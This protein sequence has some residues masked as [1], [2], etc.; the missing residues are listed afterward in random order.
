[1]KIVV[2]GA[3]GFVG[4]AYFQ[5]F[6][7]ADGLTLHGV[8]R[9]RLPLDASDYTAIDLSQPFDLPF[10]PDVVLHAAARV[11]PW[12]TR[13]EYQRQN[14]DA[15]RHVIDFCHR[16]GLPR[17]VYV[18]SSSVFYRDGHQL[19]LTEESPIGPDFVNDYAATKYEGE[20]LV[21]AY[22][23]EWTIV[24][25]RA[26][27][28]PGDTVL[29]PRIVAAARR[30]RF[31]LID[32]G[33][34]PAVGDLIY[35]DT[36]T[37]YLHAAVAS[38]R[39]AGRAFN[40]TNNQAVA[41]LPFLLDVFDRLGLPRPTRRVSLRTAMWAARSSEIAYR[42]L[43]LPGEPPITRYGVGVFAWSKTFDVSR[44]LET[45]GPP[46]VSLERGVEAFVEWQRQQW[47]GR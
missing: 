46:S 31:P 10:E 43:R 25:P 29:F 35:I 42:V 5:R 1:M 23:G 9:R 22:P 26:V 27:F 45:F 32:T 41:L 33:A 13:A 47:A 3:S 20:R 38:P 30:G 8:G 2:T 39:A 40:L 7:H 6:R 37:D 11:S 21:R 19:G 24:R 18:S 12:G 34:P 15:T 14:V 36:L 44:A 16:R 17:L 4:G 28:G